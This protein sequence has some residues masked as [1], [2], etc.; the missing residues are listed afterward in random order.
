MADRG[1][2]PVQ[3]LIR[4]D[5]AGAAS[6]ELAERTAL[7]FP[8]AVRMASVQ[9]PPTAVAE[10]LRALPDSAAADVL[11]PVPAGEGIERVLLRTPRTNG[12]DLAG[13]LK[14]AA[15]VRSA[16]KAEPVRIE[17]D[18]RALP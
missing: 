13:A 14:A 16:R 17:L 8:P 2:P 12:A 11:G 18:P 4:W 10:L 1:L 7:G 6:R 5:P 3:A 9:G 15:G